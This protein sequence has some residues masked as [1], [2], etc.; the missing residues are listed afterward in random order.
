M[1]KKPT[2]SS[3]I[4]VLLIFGNCINF[5]GRMWCNVLGYPEGLPSAHNVLIHR[6]PGSVPSWVRAMLENVYI[7]RDG[8]QL[9]TKLF[10]NSNS[11]PLKCLMLSHS[12]SILPKLT[13]AQAK[14][15]SDPETSNQ[16]SDDSKPIF[17]CQCGQYMAEGLV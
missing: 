1:V 8:K 2:N 17:F 16:G 6:L 9:I 14:H 12:N 3:D 4:A 10:R 15:V 7:P 11:T 13:R 5:P